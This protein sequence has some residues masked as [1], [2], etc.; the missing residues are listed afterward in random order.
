MAGILSGGIWG[1][2]I[3]GTDQYGMGKLEVTEE[4]VTISET[5]MRMAHHFRSQADTYT[6]TDVIGRQAHHMRTNVESYTF[7][8]TVDALLIMGRIIPE[9]VVISD[10]LS[11]RSYAFEKTKIFIYGSNNLGIPRIGSVDQSDTPKIVKSTPFFV[12]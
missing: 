4:Y 11:G 7:I 8:D 1:Y 6:I 5:L 12:R 3:Y 10:A 9:T 2:G